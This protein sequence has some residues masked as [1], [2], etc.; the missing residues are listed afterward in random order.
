[1]TFIDHEG[2]TEQL[3]LMLK[4]EVAHKILDRVAALLAH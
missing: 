2:K 1:V 3:P 4:S